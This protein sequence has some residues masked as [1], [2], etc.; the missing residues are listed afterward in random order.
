MKLT[1]RDFTLGTLATVLL[2]P[3]ASFA[4]PL[5]DATTIAKTANPL[6]Y[7][8]SWKTS[9]KTRVIYKGDAKYMQA[10]QGTLSYNG[11]HNNFHTSE[12]MQEL[13]DIYN[14]KEPLG[15]KET[16]IYDQTDT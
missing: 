2:A 14:D 5:H 16:F 12:S 10:V 1:R 9:G 3:F 15:K 13:W 8:L 4:K 11:V 7:G 6:Y